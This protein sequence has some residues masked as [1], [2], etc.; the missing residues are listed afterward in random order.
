VDYHRRFA[1]ERLETRALLA[2]TININYSI[3]S[4][5][6]GIE[7]AAIQSAAAAAKTVFTTLPNL[8]IEGDLAPASISGFADGTYTP[9]KKFANLDIAF[10]ITET[11]NL[12]GSITVFGGTM[13]PVKGVFKFTAELEDGTAVLNGSK[14]FYTGL[15]EMH[16]TLELSATPPPSL[17]GSAT[18]EGEVFFNGDSIHVPPSGILPGKIEGALLTQAVFKFGPFVVYPE[19]LGGGLTW[20]IGIPTQPFTLDLTKLGPAAIASAGA[21]SAAALPTTAGAPS[22]TAQANAIAPDGTAV[23]LVPE[24]PTGTVTVGSAFNVV[25]NAEDAQN[26]I[27][28]TFNGPVTITF[29]NAYGLPDG[30][31]TVTAAGGVAEFDDVAVFTAGPYTLDATSPGLPEASVPSVTATPAVATQLAVSPLGGDV[32]SGGPFT[33][34]VVALDPLGNP[35]PT[36]HGKVTLALGTNP[37]GAKLGGTLTVTA[38][39]GVAT[40]NGLSISK[41]G[42]GYTLEATSHGLSADTGAAFTVSNEKLAVTTQPPGTVTA[43][44]PFGLVVKVENGKGQV[45]KTFGGSVTLGDPGQTLGGVTTVPV[46]KGVATFSGLTLDQAASGDW[47]NVQTSG[48]PV[49]TTNSFSVVAGAVTK[50]AVITPP[51]ADVTDGAPFAMDVAVEDAEGNVVTSYSG[52]VSLAIATG[53]GTLTGASTPAPVTSGVAAFTGLELDPT[54]SYTLKASTSG[55][56]ALTPATTSGIGVTPTGVATH[57][58]FALEPLGILNAGDNFNVIVEATD[59]FGTPDSS[60]N[61]TVTITG[62]FGT[63]TPENMTGGTTGSISIPADQAG[64]DLALTASISGQ[65]AIA[66]A[67]STA[68][69]VAPGVVTQLAFA[70][71][72]ASVLAG[73]PLPVAVLAEDAFGNVNPGAIADIGLTANDGAGLAGATPTRLVLG[74]AYFP[75]VTLTAGHAASYTL[76]AAVTTPGTNLIVTSPSFT[77][78]NDQLVVTAEPPNRISVDE[79]FSLTVAA[80]NAAGQI[81]DLSG[82]VS[83]GLVNLGTTATLGGPQSVPLVNGVATFSG[84]TLD[85]PGTF[86]L[87]LTA[88]GA[89]PAVTIPITLVAGE[90]AAVSSITPAMGPLAG[91]TQVTID[92]SNLNLAGNTVYFG[93]VEASHVTFT[94]ATSITA[95]S[96]AG[97]GTVDITVV[98]TGGG[99]S[100]TSPADQF[101][102]TPGPVITSVV[103]TATTSAVNTTITWDETD[104]SGL[105]KATL[106]IDGTSEKLTTKASGK[107][108]A[109]YSFSGTV[110]AGMDS[111]VITA[112]DTSGLVTTYRGTLNVPVP[113]PAATSISPTAGPEG[114]ST[115]VAIKGTNLLGATVKFGAKAA[116]IFVSKSATKIVVK[117]PAGTAGPVNVTVTT[118]GGT[119]TAPDQF[120]YVVAAHAAAAVN[121]APSTPYLNDLALLALTG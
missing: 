118:A 85:M 39:D 17:K 35:A 5:M 48:L 70:G 23:Q 120:T 60:V 84:L 59:S 76:G 38:V 42:N 72:P 31:V 106:T 95:T 21:G 103:A 3:T 93:K 34:E 98:T 109:S 90:L 2:A 64:N 57:L 24:T 25:V 111:Y 37:S 9:A 92:G 26:N 73:A 69:T 89:V 97:A 105:G 43:G 107:T 30:T 18:S 81:V 100:A 33:A 50:L 6:F 119:A 53:S 7:N 46:L 47:L 115:P 12:T 104:A 19:L 117:T 10:S 1:V 108:A 13:V 44:S 99:S 55:G 22:G 86:A 66:P 96:P 88:A 65:P 58:E 71:L 4:D 102:Y 77:I 121:S 16:G 40:F 11:E 91:G 67:T 87:T 51:P 32:A 14:W 36:F 114:D 28:D 110:A 63:T 94:S 41:P 8:R 112:L 74:A 54:G 20:G 29:I 49:A 61:G 56:S 82:N 101:T 113:L 80:E 68:F 27:D 116:T 62:P 15:V 83:I 45:D 78:E 52:G 79:Q 75:A